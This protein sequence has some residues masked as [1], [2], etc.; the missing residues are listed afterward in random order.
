MGKLNFLQKFQEKMKQQY[1]NIVEGIDGINENNEKYYNGTIKK[2]GDYHS[3]ITQS[4]NDIDIQYNTEQKSNGTSRNNEVTTQLTNLTNLTTQLTQDMSAAS[5]LSVMRNEYDNIRKEKDSMK[6][7]VERYRK[8]NQ[9]LS[10][11]NQELEEEAINVR[12]AKRRTIKN[13]V[14]ELNEMRDQ[15]FKMS[16]GNTK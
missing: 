5:M 16:Q 10:L 8:E 13:L 3:K 11:R 14:D 15:I 1:T 7:E 2:M 6:M 4:I 9:I 12:E